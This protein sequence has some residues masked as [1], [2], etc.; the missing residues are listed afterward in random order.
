MGTFS[1]RLEVGDPQGLRYEAVEA[2]VDTGASYSVI[3]ASLLRRL[4]VVPYESAPFLLADGREVERE[5]GRTWVRLDGR[6][7][8]TLVV[9]DEEGVE[10]LLGAYTLEGLRL[11]P[12]PVGRRLIPIPGRLMATG[13]PRSL[14][15]KLQGDILHARL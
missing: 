12:D 10:P 11:A 3:P 4:G 2:L 9:F 7:Q 1:V 13:G 14:N 8:I 6:T 15:D 5:I